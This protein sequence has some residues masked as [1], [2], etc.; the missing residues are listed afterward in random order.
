[1]KWLQES[2][3]YSKS[4]AENLMRI[5]DEYGSKLLTSSDDSSNSQA[6]GNLTYTQ[7]LIL[8]GLPEEEREEIIAAHDVENMSSRE[9]QQIIRQRDEALEGKKQALEEKDQTLRKMG[10]LQV[11]LDS[12]VSNISELNNTAKLL[13]HQTG[14]NKPKL[15]DDQTTVDSRQN[16]QNDLKA[17]KAEEEFNQKLAALDKQLKAEQAKYPVLTPDEQ[18]KLHCNTMNSG[19]GEVLKLLHSLNK[20]DPVKKENFRKEA[21]QIAENMAKTLK[22]YPPV[23]KTNL[24]IKRPD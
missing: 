12:I 11:G 24:N 16:N 20:T 10:E 23:I 17:A 22:V 1:M 18:F 21:C 4:T 2:V 13:E 6:L 19:F 8:L 3:S 9:L 7:A 15:T 14:D 5:C